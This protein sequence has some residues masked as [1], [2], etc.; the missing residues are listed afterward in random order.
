MTAALILLVVLPGLAL[1]DR[2]LWLH[3]GNHVLGSLNLDNVPELHG[4]CR[5][6]RW[7]EVKESGTEGLFAY[8]CEDG[9]WWWPFPSRGQSPA[10]AQLWSRRS[11]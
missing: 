1:A 11:G 3:T 10:L 5:G 8:R 6:N 2:L 4:L 7:A 9:T